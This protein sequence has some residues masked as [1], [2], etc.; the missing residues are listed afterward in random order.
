[1]V[2]Q[3]EDGVAFCEFEE[4]FGVDD[5][6]DAVCAKRGDAADAREVGDAGVHFL[7]QHVVSA[8]NFVHL[9]ADAPAV[10]LADYNGELFVRGGRRRGQAQEVDQFED[11]QKSAVQKDGTLSVDVLKFLRGN[12]RALHHHPVRKGHGLDSCFGQKHGLD[13]LGKGHVD[14]EYRAFAGPGLDVDFAA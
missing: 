14:P 13:G 9:H 3:S 7:D 11:G 10:E 6:D 1:M 12:D 4:A 5:D 2:A 8:Q